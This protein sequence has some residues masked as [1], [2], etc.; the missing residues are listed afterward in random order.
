MREIQIYTKWK[1]EKIVKRI[2]GEN[3]LSK[4]IEYCFGKGLDLLSASLVLGVCQDFKVFG[5][6]KFP[7]SITLALKSI[8]LLLRPVYTVRL[9]GPSFGG[10]FDKKS[11]AVTP[12]V[13]C[14]IRASF[15][16]ISISRIYILVFKGFSLKAES[17]RL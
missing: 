12:S 10:G 15:T 5:I 9:V 13:S 4:I 17:L 1:C 16:Y 6:R 11:V 2:K 14:N 3:A 8:E 7:L